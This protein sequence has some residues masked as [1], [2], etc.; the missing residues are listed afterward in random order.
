MRW[1]RTASHRETGA[2]VYAGSAGN[3]RRWKS[4]D[5]AIAEEN[6]KIM[7]GKLNEV[8]FGGR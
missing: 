5:I 6:I 4:A 2:T 7:W 1:Y 8:D 3:R